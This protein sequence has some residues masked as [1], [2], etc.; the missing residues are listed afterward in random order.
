MV[1]YSRDQSTLVPSRRIWSRMA[2]AVMLLPLPD[3]F[4]KGFAAQLLARFVLFGELALDHQLRGYAGVI[5][6]RNPQ[7]Q[8]PAHAPPPGEDVH[9]GVFQHVPHVQP[10]GNVRRRQQ[11]GEN[12]T[13]GRRTTVC[14]VWLVE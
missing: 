10:A 1:K 12:G 8:V 14:S 13:V 5:G 4:D 6:A 3:P 2:V 11:H 9:L 7:G